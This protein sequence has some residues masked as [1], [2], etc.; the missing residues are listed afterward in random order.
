MYCVLLVLVYWCDRWFGWIQDE[1]QLLVLFKDGF[2]V[3]LVGDLL[4]LVFG[5]YDVEVVLV[6]DMSCI[7]C[8]QYYWFDV[9]MYGCMV[10]VLV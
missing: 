1:V 7:E 8:F 6:F 3:F 5:Q 4:L 9:G 10:Y 2:G